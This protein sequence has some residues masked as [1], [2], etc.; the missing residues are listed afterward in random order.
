MGKIKAQ[1]FH[2]CGAGGVW[3]IFYCKGI[4]TDV[5]NVRVRGCCENLFKRRAIALALFGQVDEVKFK[6]TANG[7]KLLRVFRYHGASGLPRLALDTL[8]KLVSQRRVH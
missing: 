6:L 7:F 8:Y 4:F 1:Y 2:P 3:L 5:L